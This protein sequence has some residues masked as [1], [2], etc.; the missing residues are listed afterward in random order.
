MQLVFGIIHLQDA[1]R[2]VVCDEVVISRVQKALAVRS[3]SDEGHFWVSFNDENH[4]LKEGLLHQTDPKVSNSATDEL[5]QPDGRDL[6][7][8]RCDH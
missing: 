1:Y 4:H 5:L 2:A 7:L 3:V 6:T 8:K